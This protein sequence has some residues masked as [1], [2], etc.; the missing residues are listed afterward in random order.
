MFERAIE[1]GGRSVNHL[2]SLAYAK[3]RAGDAV[4]ARGLLAELTTRAREGFA[5]PVWIGL[6]HYGLGEVD[7]AFEWLERAV[8]ERDGSMILITAAPDL[9]PLRADPRY[10]DTAGTYGSGASRSCPGMIVPRVPRCVL[11]DATR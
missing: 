7:Q 4:G 2:S 8:E 3:A 9:D 1:L 11:D 10:S 5:A 6:A